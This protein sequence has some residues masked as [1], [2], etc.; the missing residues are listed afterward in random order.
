MRIPPFSPRQ[1]HIRRD[2]NLQFQGAVSNRFFEFSPVFCRFSPVTLC[3]L[4]RKSPQNVEKIARF[5][6]GEKSIESRHVSGCHGFWVPTQDDFS[7]QNVNWRPPKRKLTPSNMS[8]GDLHSAGFVSN[9]TEISPPQC[10]SWRV[11]TCILFL[12]RSPP[13]PQRSRKTFRCSGREVAVL[14]F[15]R[16]GP[17]KPNERKVS[18]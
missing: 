3:N 11:S 17:G 16:S 6:G 1:I 7:L 9:F 18:S 4:A 8:I 14:L 15:V 10:T 13:P 2:R 12:E 5:P